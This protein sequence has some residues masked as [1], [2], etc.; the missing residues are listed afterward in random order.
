MTVR[1]DDPGTR[2]RPGGR[3]GTDPDRGVLIVASVQ[4]H[5]SGMLVRFVGVDTRKAAEELRG[6][7]LTIPIGERGAA[8]P[9]AWWDDELVGLTVVDP[10]GTQL[11]RVVAV[12]HLPGQDR[13]ELQT[14]ATPARV[15]FV[16][17]VRAM[18]P[19]VDVA[20]GRLVLDPPD[21]LLAL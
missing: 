10:S 2:F 14:L 12:H 19:E 11:G 13:L 9:E 7:T 17:F 4:D 5:G 6:I 21:G 1:T 3:L 20:G 16:P 15:V 8:G 18:V